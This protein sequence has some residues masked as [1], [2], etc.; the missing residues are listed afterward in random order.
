MKQVA[1]FLLLLGACS[2]HVPS[3]DDELYNLCYDNGTAGFGGIG[4]KNLDAIV[5]YCL[6]RVKLYHENSKKMGRIPYQ[7][8][9]P[10]P[11]NYRYW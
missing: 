1:S 6:G 2:Y 9:D 10:T 7:P 4:Q 3:N 11:L 5:E 8:N